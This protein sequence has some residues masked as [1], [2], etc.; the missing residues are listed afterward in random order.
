LNIAN[1]NDGGRKDYALAI[2]PFTLN[3]TEE[4]YFPIVSYDEPATVSKYAGDFIRLHIP[5]V[6]AYYD[7][8]SGWPWRLPIGAYTFSLF[9]TSKEV[10]RA[11]AACKIWV[12]DDSKLHFARA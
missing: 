12:D 9:A 8:G 7:I 6:G 10:G 4:R 3:S 2:E 5:V 1:Q 11:E